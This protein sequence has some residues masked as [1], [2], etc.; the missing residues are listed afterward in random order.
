MGQDFFF[1][2][3]ILK[4]LTWNSCQISRKLLIFFCSSIR[5]YTFEYNT[6]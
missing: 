5:N 2:A 4:Y 3:G 1:V 6:K